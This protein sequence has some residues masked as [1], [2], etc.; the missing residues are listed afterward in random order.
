MPM[1]NSELNLGA[2]KKRSSPNVHDN[3]D[4]GESQTDTVQAYA[5]KAAR[6]RLA[7]FNVNSADD[8][9]ELGNDYSQEVM[10]AFA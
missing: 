8:N 6:E 2:L 5:Q 9:R 1:Y 10:D 4:D 7:S 3:N